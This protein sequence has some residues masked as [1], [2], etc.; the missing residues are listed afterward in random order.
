MR[1][2]IIAQ[3]IANASVTRTAEGGPYRRQYVEFEP[4]EGQSFSSVYS[5]ALNASAGSGVRVSAVQEDGSDFKLVYD[6]THADAGEDGYV[7]LPNVD[8]ATEM[9]DMISATRAYEA[10]VTALN[11]MKAMAMKALEI[12]K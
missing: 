1:M 3:N 12:G 4:M 2:D 11:A 6:P 5:D 8:L 10:N 7:R 9:V